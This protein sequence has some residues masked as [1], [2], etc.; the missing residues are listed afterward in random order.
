VQNQGVDSIPKELLNVVTYLR[1]S[2]ESGLRPREGI[3]NGKRVDFFKG[4]R[5]DPLFDY[6][7]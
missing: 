2:K 6:S 3:I 5:L 4:K 7:N 1:N